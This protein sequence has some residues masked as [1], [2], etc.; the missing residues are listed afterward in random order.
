[1]L[2]GDRVHHLSPTNEPSEQDKPLPPPVRTFSLSERHQHCLSIIL[3]PRHRTHLPIWIGRA[4]RAGDPPFTGLSETPALRN[5]LKHRALNTGFRG[6]RK[7]TC[8]RQRSRSR[9]PAFK[10]K[11]RL[12]SLLWRTESGSVLNSLERKQEAACADPPPGPA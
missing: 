5:S 3:C 8:E 10:L 1:M 6:E 2:W 9:A 4:G 11:G 7:H 12:A